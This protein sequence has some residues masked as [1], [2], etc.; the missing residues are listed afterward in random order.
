MLHNIVQKF[1]MSVLF[2]M[3]DATPSNTAVDRRP[4]PVP[5]EGAE[6]EAGSRDECVAMSSE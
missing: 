6:L 1:L 3:A 5:E 4:S 2:D